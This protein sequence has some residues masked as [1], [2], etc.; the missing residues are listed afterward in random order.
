MIEYGNY[1]LL[2]TSFIRKKAIYYLLSLMKILPFLKVNCHT[3]HL[4]LAIKGHFCLLGWKGNCVLVSLVSGDR[5]ATVSFQLHFYFILFS[6]LL[7][8]L[9]IFFVVENVSLMIFIVLFGQNRMDWSIWQSL[10][11]LDLDFFLIK[12]AIHKNQTKKI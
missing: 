8:K 4:A 2:F 5:W 6:F 11:F 10:D 12:T 3:P 9:E 1:Y 7:K